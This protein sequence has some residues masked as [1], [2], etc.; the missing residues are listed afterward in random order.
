M[1]SSR[2]IFCICC[3]PGRNL[4][5]KEVID[6]LSDGAIRR[7]RLDSSRHAYLSP[8]DRTQIGMI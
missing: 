6:D 8:T 5:S 2:L 3:T 4:I 1:I 7:L